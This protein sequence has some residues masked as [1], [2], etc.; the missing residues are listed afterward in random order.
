MEFFPQEEWFLGKTTALT[1][2]Q[3]HCDAACTAVW[4]WELKH[5]EEDVCQGTNSALPTTHL[6]RAPPDPHDL[7]KYVTWRQ[8]CQRNTQEYKHGWQIIITSLDIFCCSNFFF[9]PPAGPPKSFALMWQDILV[10]LD[11]PATLED[12]PNLKHNGS[13]A[14]TTTRTFN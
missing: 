9:L 6:C 3:D 11:I 8:W 10:F 1:S 13:K 4:T 7:L 12:L 14:N 5:L 2:M